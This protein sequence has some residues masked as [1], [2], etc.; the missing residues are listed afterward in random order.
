M[1]SN[2]RRKPIHLAGLHMISSYAPFYKVPICKT[3]FFSNKYERQSLLML[4][5]STSIGRIR[6]SASRACVRVFVG[7]LPAG[8]IKMINPIELWNHRSINCKFMD[9][10]CSR[11]ARS[12]IYG[13]QSK[14][15]N[16]EEDGME[17]TGHIPNGRLFTASHLTKASLS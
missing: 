14:L 9:M 12:G 17:K 4:V 7:T 2:A 10:M 16:P 6:G 3:F 1:P 15:G 11:R 8:R 5:Y 13:C